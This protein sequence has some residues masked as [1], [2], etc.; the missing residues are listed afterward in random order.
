MT[1]FKTLVKTTLTPIAL[2]L[3]L[4]IAA[5]ATAQKGHHQKHDGMPQILSELSLTDTQK[6]DIRQVFKQTREDRDVFKTDDKSLRTELRSIIQSTEW[7]QTVLES[8]ITQHQALI[9]EK[10]LQ[11]ASNRNRV[12][13]LLTD[14]QQT[15]FIAQLETRKAKR[16]E[17]TTGDK[18]KNKGN[19]LNRLDLTAEQLAAVETIKTE[20]KQSSTEIK[21]SLKTYKQTEHALI[22]S[23]GFNVQAWQ[24][25]NAQYQANFI[26]MAV[27]KAKTKYSIWNLLTAE[28]KTVAEEKFKGKT[29]K[30]AKK[31]KK[32][33]LQESI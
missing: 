11:R 26:A 12:W 15:E 2:C 25:L 20:A 18:R 32:H 13:N 5:P 9:Q 14:T 3:S 6:Q 30:H 22:H 16:E 19:R 21:T 8:A 4:A 27:L 7:D 28:Q 24:T 33:H 1:T 10:A 29:G 31:S 23:S 17:M